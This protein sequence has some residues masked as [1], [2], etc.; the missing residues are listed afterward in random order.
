MKSKMTADQL[1]EWRLGIR[2]NGRKLSQRQ[3][4]EW[5]GIGLRTYQSYENGTPIPRYIELSAIAISMCRTV[6]GCY[7]Q[8]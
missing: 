5:M 2:V 1:R 8:S 3:A 4:A 7:E 6:G